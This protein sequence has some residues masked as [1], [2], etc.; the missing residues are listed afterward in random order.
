MSLLHKQ[1]ACFDQ[2]CLKISAPALLTN[3]PHGLLEVVRSLVTGLV[4]AV[5]VNNWW[6]AS[7]HA[8]LHM[9]AHQESCFREYAH[10]DEQIEMQAVCILLVLRFPGLAVMKT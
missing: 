8:E 10:G 2:A 1:S 5:D 9:A 7:G 3:P 6:S 4:A